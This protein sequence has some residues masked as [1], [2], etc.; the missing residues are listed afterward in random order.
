MCGIFGFSWS[1]KKLL[2]DMGKVIAHRGPDN[3]GYYVDSNISLGNNRLSIIGLQGGKQPIY[4]ED[5][6]KVLVFNG[7][8]YNYKELKKILS[9]KGHKF[10]TATDT[11]VIIH[12]YEEW[13][14]DFIEMLEGAFSFCIWD[15][16]K[17]KI[18]LFR[19]R[20]GI[21]PLYYSRKGNGIIFA[22]EIK[23]ILVDEEIKR[24]VNKN[25]LSSFLSFRCSITEETMFKGIFKILPGSYIIF[26]VKSGRLTNNRYW[27][28][29]R[30]N[31]FM[32]EK[33]FIKKL[34]EMLDDSTKNRMMSEVPIG[35]YLSGGID[36]SAIVAIMKKY[37][38]NV[39]TFS[40]GFENSSDEISEAER[41]SEYIGT[42]H[43]SFMLESKDFKLMD[44]VIWHLDEPISDPTCLPTY[45]LSKEAKKHCSVVIT[46]E[47]ADEQFLGYEQYRVMKAYN[48]YMKS[49][50]KI[51]KSLGANIV[52]YAGS[53]KLYPFFPYARGIGKAGTE[54]L[55]EFILSE[56]HIYRYLNLVSVF[57]PKEKCNFIKTD[58]SLSKLS[59]LIKEY[60]SGSKE[61]DIL[62][63]IS[64]FETRRVM[65]ESLLMKLDKMTMASSIEGRVPFLKHDF[66]DFVSSIPTNIRLKGMNEK[67][68]LRKA[69]KDL[70]PREVYNK[71]K[72]RFS[73]P[74]H[75][76][77]Y[78]QI[79]G[80]SSDILSNE[81]IK[82][83]G[84]FNPG[85]VDMLFKNLR[86]SPLIYGRQIW[87]LF[88]FEKWRKM[89]VEDFKKR[90]PN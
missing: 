22:S 32:K 74:V 72:R 51:V 27:S 1:D 86:K 64:I 35:A 68:V 62:G 5:K 44:K 75:K 69:V 77:F 21:K 49:L 24:Q 31:L 23:S 15:S 2:R 81:N 71:K 65:P 6:S 17:K 18:I 10:Y 4:N 13:G 42:D 19:D 41:V 85:Y 46:G 26:D 67:Y 30:R 54:R 45:K 56:D 38:K 3:H 25:A 37:S 34:R 70:V 89:Y 58:D 82:E 66:V 55:K 84:Y 88:C 39:K 12:S 36:S 33:C 9:E 7:E 59:P 63:K 76:V 50:P 80:L 53:K 8:I 28:I 29:R 83:A 90:G 52:N 79:K 14:M 60:F 16:D 48:D 87:S 78:E 43:R 11:E 47:G 20:L 73:V 40:I 57:S 61:E